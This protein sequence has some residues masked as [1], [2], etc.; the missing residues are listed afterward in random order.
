[1][2]NLRGAADGARQ[3]VRGGRL[4]EAM[5]G[6]RR[7]GR[8]RGRDRGAGGNQSVSRNFIHLSFPAPGFLIYQPKTPK[9]MSV[10]PRSGSQAL[11]L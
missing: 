5:G 11:G 8:R 6:E 2:K 10:T 4:G 3:L 1:M 9:L 7:S